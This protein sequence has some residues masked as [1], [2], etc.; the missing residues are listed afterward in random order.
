LGNEAQPKEQLKPAGSAATPPPP[1]AAPVPAAAAPTPTPAV[2]V[3]AKPAVAP[4]PSEPAGA[5]YAIQLAALGKREEADIIARRLVGK[6]FSAYVLTPE[7][8]APAV[9]R[10]RVGKF[11]DRREAESV[12]ARLKKE[13]QFN[14][15]IVR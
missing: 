12:A 11:K 4:A 2:A 14:P 9:F 6:G 15:W 5:G 1:A 8:G 10:V 3:A 7:S 13:E